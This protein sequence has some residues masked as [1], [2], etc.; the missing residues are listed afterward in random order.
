MTN[1]NW[2]AGEQTK[3]LREQ[4]NIK[5]FWGSRKQNTVKGRKKI[6]IKTSK[7]PTA[8]HCLCLHV[9]KGWLIFNYSQC[10]M[11]VTS[12]T[13]DSYAPVLAVLINLLSRAY[14]SLR[15]VRYEQ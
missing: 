7:A 15:A 1:L 2:G 4:G 6:E 12:F 3:Y 13:H 14:L 11:R 5:Q 8:R 9:V 10:K